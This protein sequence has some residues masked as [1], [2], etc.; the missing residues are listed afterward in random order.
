MQSQ[1]VPKRILKEVLR[2]EIL[3]EVTKQV[4][5]KAVDKVFT[6]QLFKKSQQN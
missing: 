6:I 3:T 4:L 2:Q 5:R 1:K